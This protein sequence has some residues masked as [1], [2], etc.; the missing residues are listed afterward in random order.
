[1]NHLDVLLARAAADD[2]AR[3]LN[4]SRPV[5]RPL[6]LARTSRLGRGSA[7]ARLHPALGR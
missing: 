3:D 2:R 6:L 5:R 7:L 4:R 1:M